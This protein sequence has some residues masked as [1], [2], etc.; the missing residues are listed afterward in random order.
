MEVTDHRTKVQLKYAFLCQAFSF[1]LSLMQHEGEEYE[2]GRSISLWAA[3]GRG[4]QT[5]SCTLTSV[6]KTVQTSEAVPRS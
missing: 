6:R 3:G 2:E 5:T 1:F 4:T